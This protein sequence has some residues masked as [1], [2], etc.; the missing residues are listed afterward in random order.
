MPNVRAREGLAGIAIAGLINRSLIARKSCVHQVETSLGRKRGVMPRQAGRQDAI[1]D[2]DAAQDAVDQVFGRT[3][4]H[5]VA[6]LVL[7]QQRRDHIQHGVH[8]V[9]GFAHRQAPDGNPGRIERSDKLSGFSPQVRV[10]AAL[11]NPEQSLVAALLRLDA[12]LRPAVSQLHGNFAVGV[13]VGIGTFVEGHDDV[14]A[15]ILLDADGTLGR[16][17]V[18]RAVNVTLEGHALIVDLASLRQRENLEAARIGQHGIGPAHEAMQSAHLGDEVIARAQVEVI[19]V[20]QDQRS[21][22]VFELGGSE[23]LDRSLCADRCED[24]SR[25][26]A[27]RG[28]KG[29]CAGA[30]VAGGDCEFKHGGDCKRELGDLK[31]GIRLIENKDIRILEIFKCL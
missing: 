23:G 6:R 9:F 18:R 15:E 1:E 3:D 10:D 2:V 21:A 5:Q 17:A 11:H 24:G 31:F 28:G 16:E 26:I 4:S 25:Q 13:V 20:A 19:G 29:P 30:V 14:R 8:L 12:T 7:G 27:V 22:E